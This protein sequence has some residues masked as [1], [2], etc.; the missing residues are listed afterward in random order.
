[1]NN[2]FPHRNALDSATLSGFTSC[3]CAFFLFIWLCI[4]DAGNILLRKCFLLNALV[5]KWCLKFMSV[6]SGVFFF[7]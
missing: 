2:F 7:F 5:L 3:S 4:G 6:C 1:M